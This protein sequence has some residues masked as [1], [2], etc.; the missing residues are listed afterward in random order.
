[1]AWS[2]AA[3]QAAAEARRANAR[4]SGADAPL[5]GHP[6]HQKSDAQLRF[7]Q[8]DASEAAQNMRGMDAKAEGKYLDQVNDAS[9]VLGYRSRGGRD[10]SVV[11]DKQ[12]AAA[13]AQG[14]AK[15]AAVPV[16]SGAAGRRPTMTDE[17]ARSVGLDAGNKS[18]RAGGR[19][20]WNDEDAVAATRAHNQAKGLVPRG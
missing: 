1:M 16:H 4:S 9:T 6:Y 17:M 18:M 8:R 20:V 15:S 5:Q 14:G 7:I 13:L 3:R 10:F 2:D 11:S 12:A 19:T